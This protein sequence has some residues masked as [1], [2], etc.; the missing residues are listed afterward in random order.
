MTGPRRAASDGFIVVAV[1]WL[2]AALSVLA[3]IY[4]VYVANTSTVFGMTSDRLQA[5]A[6][7]KAGLEL[8]VYG[9]TVPQRRP[10]V[11]TYG[12][13]LGRANVT[14][15]FRS[16]A[17]RIDLNTAPKELLAGLFAGL[18]VRADAASDYAER[19]VRW[20]TAQPDG[21]GEEAALYRAA[22]RPYAPRQAPFPH[23]GEIWLVLGLPEALVTRALPFVTV[24]SGKPA[25]NIVAA[26][27]EVVAGLPGM[28]A[29]RLHA[30][31]A[32]RQAVAADAALPGL[33]GPAAG[34]AT[35]DAGN[36]FRVD[37]DVALDTGRLMQSEIVIF[38]DEQDA[39]PYRVL[40]WSDVSDMPAS[41]GPR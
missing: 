7:V 20:R 30:V 10:A 4:A 13:R 33:L 3:T 1:L 27:P 18:G 6:L 17:A 12:F 26:A 9:I 19:I 32:Q 34:F 39:E 2:V 28:T 5:E 8:T 11:G 14:T 29:E 31:L 37:V 25:V 36:T 41:G 21:G 35:T 22:G 24:Y 40:S 38:V 15:R 16:E 23:V